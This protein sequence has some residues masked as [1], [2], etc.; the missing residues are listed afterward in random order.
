MSQES[1]NPALREAL[2][3]YK[4]T[5]EKGQ[6]FGL[7]P[8]FVVIDGDKKNLSTKQRNEWTLKYSKIYNKQIMDL[9]NN[10]DYQDLTPEKKIEVLEKRNRG[11]KAQV[12]KEIF[13]VK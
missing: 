13:G 12:K 2:N 7:A 9:I 4:E 11:A 8:R 3:L 1:K 10:K 5:G 6:L